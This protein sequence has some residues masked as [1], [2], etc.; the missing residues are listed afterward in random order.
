MTHSPPPPPADTI[1]SFPFRAK[2]LQY[3]DL[4][5]MCVSN[6]LLFA[7]REAKLHLNNLV[8]VHCDGF[9]FEGLSALLCKCRSLQHLCLDGIDFLEDEMMSSLA[10][11]LQCLISI[12][13]QFV[14]SIV[15]L[16][17]IQPRKELSFPKL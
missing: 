8:L 5:H 6:D 3:L 12:W 11:H 10:E 13:S 7:I 9:T 15:E 4:S 2:I 16:N 17:V 14:H 1:R